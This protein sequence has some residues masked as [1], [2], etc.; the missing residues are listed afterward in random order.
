MQWNPRSSLF[1]RSSERTARSKPG[2]VEI[3]VA[4]TKMLQMFSPPPHQNASL[5]LKPSCSG[6]R[7]GSRRDFA[8]FA[9]TPNLA[10]DRFGPNTPSHTQI[11]LHLVEIPP[12]IIQ[13]PKDNGWVHRHRIV[14]CSRRETKAHWKEQKSPLTTRAN[15]KNA[16]SVLLQGHRLERGP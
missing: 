10:P 12:Y 3:H 4:A 6:P 2:E 13:G 15:W 14:Q 9:H 7:N 16:I 11:A 5:S 8:V 1:V